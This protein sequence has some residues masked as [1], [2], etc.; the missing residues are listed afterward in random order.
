M[1][2]VRTCIQIFFLAYF[3]LICCALFILLYGFWTLKWRLVSTTEHSLLSMAYSVLMII[4]TSVIILLFVVVTVSMIMMRMIVLSNGKTKSALKKACLL[5]KMSSIPYNRENEH[6]KK[7]KK[8][9]AHSGYSIN[10]P[11]S[12][13]CYTKSQ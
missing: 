8:F 11:A 6:F 12:I 7:R 4:I 3:L 1:L 13:H 9:M 10:W 5:T 2:F